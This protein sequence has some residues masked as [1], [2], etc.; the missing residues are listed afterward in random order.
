MKRDGT[1]LYVKY[2]SDWRHNA[3]LAVEEI[4][5]GAGKGSGKRIL[6]VPEQNSFDAEAALCRRGGDGISRS[7][8]VLSFTRL[9]DRVFSVTG[10]G[11]LAVLEKSGRMIAM[12]SALEQLRPKL[13]LY[14]AHTAKP[15]FLQELL[16]IVDEFHGYG[17]S[18]KSVRAAEQNLSGELSAKLE[19]LCLILEAYDAVC[20]GARQDPSTRLDRLRDA[21]YDSDYAKNAW[22]VVSGFSDFT[23]QELGV[24]EALAR[25]AEQVTVY[26]TLDALSRGQSVFAVPRKTAND[27]RLLAAR[28]N[29]YV[30]FAGLPRPHGRPTEDWLA[31]QLFASRMKPMEEA[32]PDL[33]L[34][35]CRSAAEEIACA[36]GR[37]QQLMLSGVRWRDIA[38]AYTD[39]ALYAPLAENLLNR[40]RIPAYFSGAKEIL[41]QPVIRA[42]VYA[43][44]AAAMGMEPESVAEYLKTGYAPVDGD[45]A[46]RIENYAYVWNLRGSRWEAPFDR[47]PVGL[48]TEEDAG[49]D[50][51]LARRLEALNRGRERAILPLLELRRALIRAKNVGGQVL[52]LEAFL[53]EI[54]LDQRLKALADAWTERGDLQRA[55]ELSQLYEILLDTMEQ[56]YGVLADAVRSPEDF[57]RFFRSALTQNTVGSVPATLDTLRVGQLS[58]MR[59]LRVSHLFLLGASDGLLPVADGR[60]GLLTEAERRMMQL[61]GL[62]VAPDAAERMDRE[63][64]TAYTVLTAPTRSLWVSCDQ[65]APSFL[66]TR[67]EKL[68]PG[69]DRTRYRPLPATEDQAAARLAE[70]PAAVRDTVLE[71]QPALTAPTRTILNRASY[72]PGKL[73]REAVGR[74]YGPRISLNPTRVDLFAACKYAF[75]LR[76]GLGIRA[77]RQ[78]AVDASLY[79]VFVH[80]VLQ[81][82]VEAVEGEGG[83][84]RVSEARTLE[85]AESLCEAFV[86]QQLNGLEDYTRRGSYLF[87]RNYR[88]VLAVVRELYGEL[89]RSEFIPVDCELQFKDDTAIPITGKLALGCLNGVV[90]RVDLYTDSSGKTYLRVVDYKTGHKE[91]DYTEILE[92]MGLQ[93]L[94]YLF[95]LT[96]EA[97]RF[98][99][100]P[101]EPAG[102][103]YFPARYDVESANGRPTL[104]EAEKEHRKKLRRKGLLLD[105]EG[106][107]Q[108]MEPDTDPIYLP[109]RT[110]KKTGARSGDLAS[111]AQME[112][113]SRHV[114][115]TIAH[116][117]DEMAEGRIAPNP[118]WR[119]PDQ[120]ACR[121]CDY[122][123]VCHVDSGEIP[124]RRLQATPRERFWEILKQEEA[125]HG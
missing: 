23:A 11:A 26:L 110:V 31:A 20:A 84:H 8:E 87:R 57:Y 10:G 124:L 79:G 85:L 55:Q 93:M 16:Q 14:A 1:M 125:R 61:A 7:A 28:S 106:V 123:E 89:S 64:L 38:L 40:F 50:A 69:C 39:E 22:I 42:V 13:K 59:N 96:R 35:R 83:F 114:Q 90:D 92:G 98:Y 15:E 70:A 29:V 105:D 82:T 62:Q 104:E 103:L 52:A 12:A 121:W 56:I 91:F 95:A 51:G 122:R 45:M 6:I 75:F 67:L 115:R 111:E 94:I 60:G 112:L 119:G 120:N 36:V 73:D 99:G 81:H 74:L 66:F 30:R 117:A 5:A 109:Y 116:L 118:Y 2:G 9:A 24:L 3:D 97:E 49:R 19:E 100:R 48:R 41:R 46:D 107:L 25:Q 17:L 80:Y 77:Q 18:A 58:D 86:T 37:I 27:L 65:D 102:V 101:L 44:E 88:E 72:E 71:R 32:A 54:Q 21:L 78:A 113:V 43:L 53:N 33:S 34:C 108:A 68:F 63:L 47:D 76:Y 4:C